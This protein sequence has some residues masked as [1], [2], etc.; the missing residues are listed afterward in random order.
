VASEAP[1]ERPPRKD[2]MPVATGSDAPAGAAGEAAAAA[3]ASEGR[4]EGI[5]EAEAIRSLGTR[6]PEREDWVHA[7]GVLQSLFRR[8]G[9]DLSLHID[10]VNVFNDEIRLAKGDFAIGH[11]LTGSTPGDRDDTDAVLGLDR[12]VLDASITGYVRPPGFNAALEIL[13]SRHMLILS[14]HQGSGRETAALALLA[15]AAKRDQLHLLDGAN[16]VS[17][18][19]W[20]CGPHGTGF[21]VASLESAVAGRLDDTWLRRTATRLADAANFMV[22]VTGHLRGSLA[23]ASTGTDFVFD[24]L[25]LP[26]PVT[27]VRRKARGSLH[28]DLV[29]SLEI[30]LADDEVLTLLTEEGSPSFLVRAAAA[31]AEALNAEEDPTAA[32]RKLLDPHARV[33]AWFARHDLPEEPD[34]QQLVLPVAVSVLED[35]SYLTVTD[36]A[37]ALYRQL[38]PN[39]KGPPLLRFRRSLGEQQQW[40]QIAVPEVSASPYGDPSP[41][42]VSFR[43][44]LMGTAVLRYAWTQID[45]MRPAMTAW[46]LDLG[47]HPDID[48]RAR[49]AA[50]AGLLA[51]LDFSYVLHSFIY[52][53]AV[54]P[55]PAARA[56]AAIALAVPG[57]SSRF[58][59][60][61]WELLRQ[62]AA[63]TADGPGRRLPWTAAEAAGG[64][65]GQ[66][67][68]AEA[69]SVLGEVLNREEWD[70]LLAL[71]L[72]ILNL[73][74][75]GCV[76]EVLRALTDWSDPMDGSP[77]VIKAL[78]AFV[79]TAR[80]PC[81]PDPSSDTDGK[82]RPG[83][84]VGGR[85]WPVLL[86]C[87]EDNQNAL[88]DLWG[89]SLSAKQ[90]RPLALDALRIWLE[91]AS[92]D[93]TAMRPLS[94]LITAIARLG[95][96]HP[97]R[98]EYYLEKWA[99]DP[100]KPV[101]SARQLLTAVTVAR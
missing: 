67:R 37:I 50:S 14:G 8:H 81:P 39:E 17:E 95:G 68:P 63:A 64:I 85:T 36:A 69:L 89:R 33:Q 7:L 38:L 59:E 27:V 83:L 65:L 93:G 20:E 80:T 76:P 54:D 25:G 99:T 57:R 52:P 30:W 40:I 86:T 15:Q 62:W 55:V 87:A 26:D 77:P 58:A 96:K 70:S 47:D 23:T 49:A 75:S 91:I 5:T 21:F 22:V 79:I 3:A 2:G 42:L 71:V 53:W 34:Y 10:S 41:E 51:T 11:R 28:P 48:V 66:T 6:I 98:L 31:A 90:V 100:K 92:D 1:D 44:R 94:R 46:L 84:A 9:D 12:A 29:A 88:C 16:L 61:V 72:A 45:G 35:S 73:A 101:R 24:D 74:E 43:S 97:D 13:T 19:A 60:R 82:A 32:I 4:A 78:L 56:S 18:R